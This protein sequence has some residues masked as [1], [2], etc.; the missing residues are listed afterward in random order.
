MIYRVLLV[1]YFACGMMKVAVAQL[2]TFTSEGAVI[3]NKGTTKW[4]ITPY[5]ENIIKVVAEPNGYVTNEV[6]SDAV[7]LKP[8]NALVTLKPI[9]AGNYVV[10]WDKLKM[11]AKGDSL[12]F[13]DRQAVLV[14]L[15]HENEYTGFNFLLNSNERIFGGGERALPLNRRGYRFNLYN[16]PWYGYGMGA[17][18]LNYSVPFITSSNQ[19]AIF[20]DNVSKGYLDIGKSNSSIL[21][22]GAVS[23]QLNCYIILGSNYKEILNSYHKLTGTQPI[24]PRWALGNLMSRFGY[25]SEAQVKNIMRL[26]R[27]YSI[28][29]DAV[30]FDLFWFGDSIKGTMGN[31]DW[32]NKKAWTNPGKM[33]SDFK[34][35]GTQTILITEPFVLKASK[36]YTSSKLFHAVDSGNNPYVLK[37]FYFGQ[38]GLIDIFRKDSRDWFWSKYK[39]QMK[40]GVAGWW[41]DLGEPEKHPADLYHNL[42]DL[43]YKRLFKA[44]EVHN[45]Y[46][47]FWTKMLHDKYAKDYPNMRLF[48]LNRS[49]F[50]GTQRYS[51]FPWSGDVSRT[52]NGLQAQLP[53][54]LGMS[55]SGV[56]YI[57]ADAGG[58]AGGEK[59]PELY[60]RWLQFAQFTPVFRP[61]GSE[62]SAIDTSIKSYPSEPALFPQPFR[63]FAKAAVEE[64]YAMLPYTYTLSYEQAVFGKP[65]VSPVYYY[66]PTDSSAYTAEDQFMWGENMLVAPVLKKGAITRRF[67]LPKGTWFESKSFTAVE[68][69]QW[70]TDTVW[71]SSIPVYI[72]EG[73]FIPYIGKP[74]RNTQEYSTADLLITYVPSANASEYTLFDDDGKSAQ[75]LVKKAF[76]LITFS[77]SGWGP[78]PTFNI[79]SNGGS[80]IGKPSSRSITI[81][82]PGIE[83]LPA[84][85]T[86]NGIT[87]VQSKTAHGP[88]TWWDEN[89]KAAYVHFTFTG[90][91]VEI[92]MSR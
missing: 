51:I 22:F 59:D 27:D 58:F 53:V 56:P 41:G 46:G 43:G 74:V 91:P 17:D 88:A 79:K 4:T 15:H 75:S 80:F 40:K 61:H 42:K 3:I 33:I 89:M 67:Y 19:Y 23:G 52:W 49:G 60:V 30:I 26:M 39:T 85:V 18:N 29:Y 12:I 44:D 31:L 63:T 82:I 76:E 32:V 70:K 14:G 55:M 28:P 35:E 66:Y 25:T 13:G 34:K 2:P 20:F 68:G 36:N 6:I 48:S 87:A 78:Q 72:K 50:A 90:K 81:A 92:R 9:N 64:R 45:A 7:L 54:M 38:G 57:H 10:L 24:P 1:F 21:S 62:L 65:L 69:N 8:A 71:M 5:A 47:H 77:S 11:E 37:D 86:V 84:L 83:K 16:N 73:S